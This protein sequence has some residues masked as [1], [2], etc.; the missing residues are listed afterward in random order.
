MDQEQIGEFI[1]TKRKEKS[2]T[3]K[4]LADKLNISEKTISKWETGHGL[5]EVSNMQPLCKELGITVTELLNGEETKEI[6]DDKVVEYIE[7]KEK[8]N[9]RKLLITIMLFTLILVIVILLFSLFNNFNTVK[10]YELTGESENFIYGT[11]LVMDSNMK[12]MFVEGDL[13]I[14]DSSLKIEDIRYIEYLCK[15]TLIIGHA[16]KHITTGEYY[17]EDNGYNEILDKEKLNN[18]NDWKVV[19]KYETQEGVKQET[20]PL[21]AKGVMINNKLFYQ[22]KESISIDNDI[23]SYE[24]NQKKREIELKELEQKL[25]SQGFEQSKEEENGKYVKEVKDGRFEILPMIDFKS[26]SFE[27]ID[28]EY[29]VHVFLASQI[30]MFVNKN[31]DNIGINYTRATSKLTCS[32]M[33]QDNQPIII[34]CPKGIE[35]TIDKYIEIFDDEFKDIFPPEEKWYREPNNKDV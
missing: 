25:E 1:A 12:N 8:K 2:L 33:N 35:K 23:S 34:D 26:S 29:I 22:K 17:L 11:A 14:K 32:T 24:E 19:V 9:S 13:E 3:Q 30:Y 5:P 16:Y 21:K 6:K 10:M 7:Y 31:N 15:D 4:E 20:I 27:Y 28:K 18:I